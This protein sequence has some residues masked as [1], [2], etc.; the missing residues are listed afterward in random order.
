VRSDLPLP[1]REAS[2]PGRP[3]VDLISGEDCLFPNVDP[4]AVGSESP[5]E[6]FHHTRLPD[7]SDYV[8]WTD[9]FDFLV[10]PDGSS[11]LYRTRRGT[12]RD[13]LHA[14]LLGQVLSFALLK[15]GLESLHATAVV[16]DGHGVAFVADCGEGKSTLGAAFVRRGH[17]L[18]TDDLLVLERQ[19]GGYSAHPGLPRIKLFPEQASSILGH[20]TGGISL[21][22]HTTKLIVPLGT[23][24]YHRGAVPI[25]AIYVLSPPAHTST[26]TITLEELSGRGAFLDLT[27]AA[28]NLVITDSLRLSSLFEAACCLAECVP[29]RRLRYAR[30]I[31]ELPIVCEAVLRDLSELTTIG[32]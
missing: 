17:P 2:E 20:D 29:L 6:W 24:R 14:Y 28:F 12:A 18:L 21:N 19:E 3:C 26:R 11:I 10:S 16:V 22:R 13:S 8:C 9:H 1:C 7:G 5:V 23:S 4:N 32:P 15:K 31:S 25:R 30:D 27:R